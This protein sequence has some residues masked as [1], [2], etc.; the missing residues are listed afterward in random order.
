[1]SLSGQQGMIFGI[2]H[3]FLPIISLRYEEVLD[4]KIY[5][6]CLGFRK[7]HWLTSVEL[8]LVLLKIYF[9]NVILCYLV[10]NEIS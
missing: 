2:Y 9:F 3:Y 5:P 1:M 8:L 7:D 10:W 4:E 6:K